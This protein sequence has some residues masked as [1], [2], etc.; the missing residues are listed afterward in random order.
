MGREEILDDMIEVGPLDKDQFLKVK[1]TLT[2]IGVKYEPKDSGKP[3]LTQQC[4]VLHSAGRYFICH[5]KQ[6]FLLDGKAEATNYTDR[7]EDILFKTVNLLEDW[8]LVKP[9]DEVERVGVHVSVVPYSSKQDYEL[10]SNYKLG[11]VKNGKH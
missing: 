1:E 11:K 3:R 6:L 9:L 7:D 10:K 4:H 2:R 5:F 8:G